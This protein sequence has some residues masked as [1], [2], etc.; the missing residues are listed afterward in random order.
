MCG[1][2]RPRRRV[3]SRRDALTAQQR[4]AGIIANVV[5]RGIAGTLAVSFLA[6]ILLE[7]KPL[8]AVHPGSRQ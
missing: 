2:A 1:A 3:H 8:E 4:S 7:E 5:L 6:V